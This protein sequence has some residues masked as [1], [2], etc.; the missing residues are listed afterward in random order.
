M[1]RHREWIR[2]CVGAL[3]LGGSV[4]SCSRGLED[5]DQLGTTGGVPSVLS[6]RAIECR[7]EMTTGYLSVDVE[8]RGEGPFAGTPIDASSDIQVMT[9]R[10]ADE[11][12]AT[13]SYSTETT[14]DTNV[15]TLT[16]ETSETPSVISLS[17]LTITLLTAGSVESPSLGDLSGRTVSAGSLRATIRSV[18]L[19]ERGIGLEFSLSPLAFADDFVVSALQGIVM[20][21]DGQAFDDQGFTSTAPRE[22][23]LLQ[24]TI[25]PTVDQPTPS[26]DA[27]PVQLSFDGVIVEHTGTIRLP[28]PSRCQT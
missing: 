21:L 5:A 8:V 23:S 28:L 4:G 14:S 13:I 19:L 10:A 15:L 17:N 18:D 12:D 26:I 9:V 3:L 6:A 25:L 7:R 11:E 22:D 20:Q 27:G 24:R 16:L 1:P 2:V